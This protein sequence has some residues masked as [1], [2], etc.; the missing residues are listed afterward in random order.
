MDYPRFPA[1]LRSIEGI[2]NLMCHMVTARYKE[3]GIDGS[4]Q[5]EGVNIVALSITRIEL[6]MHSSIRLHQL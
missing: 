3:N 1:S 6:S 5:L 4:Q 2:T